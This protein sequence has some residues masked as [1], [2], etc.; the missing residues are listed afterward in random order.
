MKTR[1]LDQTGVPL[2]AIGLGC[3]GMSD[4]AAGTRYPEALMRFLNG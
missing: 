4:E 3:M 1:P 2:S